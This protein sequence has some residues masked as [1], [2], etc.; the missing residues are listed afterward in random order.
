MPSEALTK[1]FCGHGPTSIVVT[2]P[3]AGPGMNRRAEAAL[4]RFGSALALVSDLDLTKS[5]DPKQMNF[6]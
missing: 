3:K 4:S 1:T 2:Q 6:S 5:S